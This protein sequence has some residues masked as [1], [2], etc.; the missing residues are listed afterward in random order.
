MPFRCWLFRLED[1]LSIEKRIDESRTGNEGVAG[2]YW[3]VE[4][5][6]RI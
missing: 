4:G 3:V 1:S 2:L 6:V 5:V